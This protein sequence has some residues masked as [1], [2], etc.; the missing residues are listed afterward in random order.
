LGLSEER[1]EGFRTVSIMPP[2]G[3]LARV[4]RLLLGLMPLPLA[5]AFADWA[6]LANICDTGWLLAS[7]RPSNANERIAQRRLRAL[8]ARPISFAAFAAQRPG[9]GPVHLR[10]SCVALPGQDAARELWRLD[11]VEQADLGRVLIE[12]GNDFLLSV[13]GGGEVYVLSKGGH[14]VSGAPLRPG[15]AVSVFGFADAIP[16]A[17]GLVAS[18][19][20]RGGLVHAIRSGS[21]LPLLVSKVVR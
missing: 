7:R 19:S 21:E 12:E 9:D 4:R 6:S 8:A 1:R 13:E 10:G 18:P 14:L 3:S 15:D 5:N 17:I 20:G 11:V 2:P 16:D